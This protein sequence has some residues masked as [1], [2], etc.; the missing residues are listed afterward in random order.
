[1]RR[2]WRVGRPGTRRPATA[3]RAALALLLAATAL[4]AAGAGPAQADEVY[5]RPAS[6]VW[7]VSGH[8]WGHGHGMSAWGAYGAG[9][10]GKG[11]QEILSAYYPGTSVAT[12]SGRTIRV[13][14]TADSGAVRVSGAAGLTAVESSGARTALPAADQWRLVPS[15]SGLQL[16]ASSGGGWQAF[17]L[18]GSTTLAGPVRFEGPSLIRVW[19]PDNTSTD[20]PGSVTAVAASGTVTTV[21]TVPLETYVGGV[22]AEEI[23]PS[24]PTATLRAFAVAARSLAMQFIGRGGATYDICD[25]TQCQEFTGPTGYTSGGAATSNWY[26]STSSAATDT[27]GQYLTYQGAAATTQYSAS[28]GGWS[29]DGGLPYLPARADP[30]D[31]AAPGDP[32]HS[33]TASLP[34]AA[35]EAAFPAVGTLQRVVVTG[36]DGHGEWGGRVLSVRLEG[37]A[38][39]VTTTGAALMNARPYPAYRDG[40]RSSWWSLG[41]P[42]APPQEQPYLYYSQPLWSP[43]GTF[44]MVMQGDGNL[45]VYDAAGRAR[46][47]TGTSVLG[48]FLVMQGDG[49]LVMYDAAGAPVWT[50]AT[51]SVGAVLRMQDDGNLVLYSGYGQPLW[52]SAGFAQHAPVYFPRTGAVT[53]LPSGAS[54]ASP[55]GSFRAT[56]QTGGAAVVVRN[57][58]ATVWSTGT[59]VAGSRFAAQGDGN[60]VVY[61]PG[62]QPVWAANV[63]SPG[64]RLVMQDDGNLVDYAADGH[65]VWDSQGFT[66]R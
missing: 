40:L 8:G 10:L 62:N 1:M 27:A 48:S 39:S 63:Y 4:V 65:P 33:W 5:T 58:G 53:A 23:V 11:Y 37:S 64:A 15:G 66:R 46:W 6:G 42:A 29:T 19:R 35:V 31:G 16:Q 54:V 45:V 61:T 32:V 36:R 41:A 21:L 18:S 3:A 7:T 14:L 22:L 57:D 9:Y 55:R 50:T 17:A 38:G 20:Y 13:R 59:S 49:N 26:A 34:A 44:Q 28:N 47:A 30:W 43:S 60:V 24:W 51:S 12:V 2:L 56:M 25:T 52:D